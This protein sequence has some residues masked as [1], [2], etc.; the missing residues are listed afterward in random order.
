VYDDLLKSRD[1]KNCRCNSDLPPAFVPVFKLEL[2]LVP[3][4]FV[5]PVAVG[6][7]KKDAAQ[8]PQAGH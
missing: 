8:V 1:T 4:C 2:D 6:S 5:S 3:N 7:Q